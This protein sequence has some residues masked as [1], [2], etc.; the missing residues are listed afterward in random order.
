MG[1]PG[2]SSERKTKE[3]LEEGEPTLPLPQIETHLNGIIQTIA[4]G[5]GE[6]LSKDDKKLV[7]R[8]N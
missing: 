1:R 2:A 6:T 3:I 5:K 8:G 4:A 7:A